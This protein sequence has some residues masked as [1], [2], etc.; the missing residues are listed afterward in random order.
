MKIKSK[1][2]S[3]IILFNLSS[4]LLIYAQN[5]QVTRWTPEV[6][7]KFK[8]VGSTAVSPDGQ[9]I[10]YTVSTAVMEGEKSEFLTHIWLVS[11][12]GKINYQFTHGDKSC[13]RPSFSPDGKY[14]AFLSARGEN[15]KNQVFVAPLT[16]GDPE[17]ITHAKSGVNNYAW[18]PDGKRIAYTMNDPLTEQE[19]KNKKEKR[20]WKVLDTNYKYSHLYTISL[21]KD[22]SGHRKVQR[23]TSG[24]FHVTEF[25]WAPDGKVIAFAHR[26]TPKI[27]DW[28]TT[29]LSSVPSDSGAVT[30]LVAWAGSDSDPLYS[31]NGKWLAFVSDGGNPKWA[32]ASDI[33]IMPA[34]GGEPQKL[35]PTADQSPQI[36]A[37]LR[38]SKEIFYQETDRTSRR[39]FALPVN[40]K[41]PRVL[42]T[43][44]GNFTGVSVS[45]NGR[46]MA[47]VHQT[48]E[49]P[50]DV[51]VSPASKFQAK[52]LTSVNAD[53]PDLPM[54]KTEVIRW[55][56]TDGKEIEGLL[57]YPIDYKEGQKYPLI[58]NIHGGPAGVY[59]QFYTASSSVYPIQAFAQAGFAILRPN[60]RGSSG[61]GKEFRFANY[62]DWGFGDYED[63]MA[64]VDK[65][66]E[67]GI[68]HPESLC[69]M[70]WSYG[71]YMTSMIVTKTK[72][73]KAA[74]VGAGVTDLFSFTGTADI[75]S[76]LPDYFSGEPWDRLETYMKH[77]A[78]FNVKGVSTPTLI[79][80][81]E[82]DRR[83]PLSQGLE[84]YNALKRQGCPT[85]MVVYPRQPHGIREPKFIVDIGN[86]IL[87][88]FNKYL[89]R[90]AAGKAPVV[91]KEN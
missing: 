47:F 79:I 55:T 90:T 6:M 73:F 58:L 4:V 91:E 72:R 16:G 44:M 56:S 10:A 11:A 57:T 49:T 84:F 63:L 59:T 54:G 7:I 40:G 38:D 8:R 23:L 17:Q 85:Q 37:W 18:S 76:F 50:P 83:V 25:D 75:P 64:G 24:P 19:E 3:L 48:P 9:W 14:L 60:P 87:D 20:D 80:H 81:G 2:F 61:Y 31:P 22:E 42:T 27:N 21:Q 29:D 41:N 35:A 28:P 45:R 15:K 26:K 69:V 13:T 88:W 74:S 67:M 39:V 66:I 65:V 77:S 12:D 89:G 5:N 51:Y 86:R 36:F 53:Y 70:G 68:A 71:G 52:K 34:S 30:S 82:E 43:G 46:V 33:Y 1:I 32:F 78:M 62:N